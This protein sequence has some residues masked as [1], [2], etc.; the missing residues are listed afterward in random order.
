MAEIEAVDILA[1]PGDNILDASNFTG[2]TTLWGGGVA[3]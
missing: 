3:T 1:G 2:N